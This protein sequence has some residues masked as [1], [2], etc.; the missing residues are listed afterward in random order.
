MGDLRDRSPDDG[1][2]GALARFTSALAALSAEAFLLEP[3]APHEMRGVL[4]SEAATLLDRL[5]TRV[6][7]G[8]GA[9]DVAIGEGLASLAEGDRTLRLGY[10]GIGDYARERLGLAGR[11]AQAMAHL[12]RELK[13]R[14]LLRASVRRGEITARKAQTI[15]AVARGEAEETWV[16][17]ARV[18]TVRSLEVAI[19]TETSSAPA[20]EEVR[21]E[22][23]WVD[24]RPEQRAA[25]DQAMQVASA[26][27]GT[28]SSPWQRLEAICQEYLGAHPPAGPD[29]GA[30]VLH[31]EVAR[32]LETAKEALETETRAWSFLDSV[33]PCEA[34]DVD[35][36][37]GG[38]DVHALDAHLRALCG[39]RDRWDE[40]VGHLAMLVRMLGLWRDMKFASFGHYC[41]ERLGMASR[42]VEQRVALARRLHALPAL[43]AALRDGRIS[44][45]KA[46]LVAHHADDAS[47]DAWLARAAR[48]TCVE[49]RRAIDGAV[50]AQMCAEGALAVRIPSPVRALV[51]A[52]FRAARDAAGR[53]LSPGECL[54]EIALHFVATWGTARKPTRNPVLE[55]DRGH[56]QVPG[57]SRPA[58]HAHHVSYRSRGGG[59]ER[60]NLVSLCA[61]HHLHAVHR[62]WIRVRGRAP[63]GLEWQ[64]GVRGDGP[65]LQVFTA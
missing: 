64:L 2:A 47:V 39:M 45:E 14:P 11:T 52:A 5:L 7:R 57:C 23:V 53:W 16:R 24:V 60:E 32:W 56:C 38:R 18:E 63:D 42:T 25:F 31:F 4:R 48:M 30:E 44:Y 41:A 51:S 26:Q 28:A 20:E 46:R 49:L 43:R 40:V 34:P 61:A 12:A 22:Q 65:P 59:N 58:T 8:R 36:P 15:V 10:S 9:L 37:G 54:A 21:W 17:R 33:E 1:T 55:R 62:G 27:L 13:E 50:E 19:R 3:P 29:D 35:V 6:A